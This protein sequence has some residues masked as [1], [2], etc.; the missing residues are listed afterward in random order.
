MML[1]LVACRCCLPSCFVLRLDSHV[2]YNGLKD[3]NC[4]A[5][6][7]LRYYTVLSPW[8]NAVE[9][10]KLKLDT[11]LIT[12]ALTVESEKNSFSSRCNK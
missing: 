9:I 8:R 11:H 12:S 1:F 6:I 7:F 5:M 3:R 4:S 2:I 10:T